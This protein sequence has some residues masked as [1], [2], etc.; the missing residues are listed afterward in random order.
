[1]RGDLITVFEYVKDLSEKKI[2]S[3]FPC[4]LR[5]GQEGMGLNYNQGDKE[6]LPNGKRLVKHMTTLPREVM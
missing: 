3:Y 6:N 4:P 2:T 1:M 5:T